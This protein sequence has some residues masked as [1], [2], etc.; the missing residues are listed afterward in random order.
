MRN[1]SQT[2]NENNVAMHI[3]DCTRGLDR[4]LDLLKTYDRNDK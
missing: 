4:K 3:S 2:S 1:I